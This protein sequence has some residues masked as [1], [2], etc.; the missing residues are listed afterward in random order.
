M[1]IDPNLIDIFKVRIWSDSDPVGTE[2]FAI[3]TGPETGIFSGS[4]QFGTKTEDG[5][6][7]KV[8]PRDSVV[9]EYVDFTLPD[10]YQ[11]GNT[12]TISGTTKM[13]I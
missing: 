11:N 13:K 7:I 2:I 1:N 8:S 12:L 6:V 3:E 9:V 10:P 4:I 5:K